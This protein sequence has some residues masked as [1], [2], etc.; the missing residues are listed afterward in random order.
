MS[1]ADNSLS[2]SQYLSSST[3]S[4]SPRKPLPEI[5]KIYKQAS[6]LFLT[7]RLSEALSILDPVIRTP[8]QTNGRIK[9]DNESPPL[10]PIATATTSQR[11][12]VWSL[13]ITLIN[14]IVD[15]DIDEGRQAFGQK[16]YRAIVAR[17]RDGGIWEQVVSDGY[18]GREGSVDAEVVYNLY[19]LQCLFLLTSQH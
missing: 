14:S 5:S 11:I 3:S 16:E 18:G 8:H 13:Y 9:D 6:Q 12:K 19:G 10:P 17:V 15:L 2:N 7:R 1:T 4:L